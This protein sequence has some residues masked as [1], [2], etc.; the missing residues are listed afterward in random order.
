MSDQ[1]KMFRLGAVALAAGASLVWSGRANATIIEETFGGVDVSTTP[2]LRIG[3]GSPSG[4]AQYAAYPVNNGIALFGTAGIEAT[5]ATVAGLTG[6]FKATD[7]SVGDSVGSSDTFVTFADT[8]PTAGAWYSK[9]LNTQIENG[10][11]SDYL[12]LRFSIDGGSD[13]YGYITIV[14]SGID[15]VT[16][17]TSGSAIVIGAAP[18]IIVGA[19]EP[20]SLALLAVGAAGIAGL[21][22]R[23][24]LAA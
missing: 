17:D 4:Q 15:N 19:P 10:T 24:A 18:D 6:Q 23:R 2:L 12:G 8:S 14:G 20:A 3:D 21:R 16:Y 5:S 7:L 13:L 9:A 1:E 22:R 11:G